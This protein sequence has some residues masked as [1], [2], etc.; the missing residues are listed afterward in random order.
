MSTHTVRRALTEC[1]ALAGSGALRA[2]IDSVLPLEEVSMAHSRLV[3]RQVTGRIL[4]S[5]AE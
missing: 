4:L 3:E 1:L 5:V 2:H